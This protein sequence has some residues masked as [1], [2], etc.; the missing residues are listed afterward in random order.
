LS[1]FTLPSAQDHHFREKTFRRSF[2]A[3][4][5]IHV[6]ILAVTASITLFRMS[7]THYAP[8]YTVDLVTLPAAAP[9]RKAEPAKPAVQEPSKP[10]AEKKETKP[11]VEKKV[12]KQAP[13]AVPE[14][15]QKEMKPSGGDEA[16]AR[17]KRRKQSEELEKKVQSLLETITSKEDLTGNREPQPTD[18][19]AETPGRK[20]ATGAVSGGQGAAADIR[21]KAY[22]DRIWT[23]IRSSWVLPEGVASQSSLLTK[24]GIRIAPDGTIEQSWFEKKSGNDYY[25]QSALRAIR[26]ANPLPPLPE[27]L[28]GSPLEVGINF[29][30]PE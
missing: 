13:A 14:K 25:D 10:P 18:T 30:Y 29:R 3:S 16:A 5:G 23:K 26:K 2:L 12:Q 24:V 27:E 22:Y 7:G 11:Q 28:S 19:A 15:I 20:A 1:T 8:S 17:L 4:A 21:S 6:A 9:A